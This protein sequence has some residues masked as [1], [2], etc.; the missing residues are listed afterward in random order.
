VVLVSVFSRSS[1]AAHLAVRLVSLAEVIRLI[2]T[3]TEAGVDRAQVDEAISQFAQLGV[4]RRAVSGM[5]LATGSGAVTTS[6]RPTDPGTEE[7]LAADLSELLVAIEESPMPDQ[8]WAPI[9]Q[10]LGDDLLSALTGVSSSSLH[11]YRA[12]SRPTP[13]AVAARLHTV[14]LVVA[15]LAGSYNQFGI[16]RWFGRS[17]TALG[18]QAPRT[19]LSGEWSPEDP[20]VSH[21][22]DL[23]RALLATPST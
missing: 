4:G 9:S 3:S 21:V 16:R 11:R 20:E 7:H 8:E 10:L 17:R 1:P 6:E 5:S 12:G 13:D 22:R 14:T 18:G 23:S 2:P 19:I 15:D